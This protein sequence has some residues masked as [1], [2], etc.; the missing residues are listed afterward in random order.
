LP[1]PSFPFDIYGNYVES[2]TLPDKTVHDGISTE[3]PKM[4]NNESYHI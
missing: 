2:V 4:T 1:D 3:P